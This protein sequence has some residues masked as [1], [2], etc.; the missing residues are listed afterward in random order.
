MT[1]LLEV[2]DVVK[3]FGGG[4]IRKRFMTALDGFSLTVPADRPT[5]TAIAGESGSGKTTLARLILGIIAP[6]EGQIIYRGRD[7]AAMSRRERR[8]FRREVQ[9]IFQDPYEVYNPFYKVDHVLDMVITNFGL[10]ANADEAVRLK[11]DAVEVVGLRPDDVLGKFPHELSGGQRQRVMVARAFLSRPRLIVADEPVSMV[12]A[13]L[14]ALILE[15]MLRLRDEYRISFL[16]ITHDLSTAF[17]LSDDIYVLYQ[18]AVAEMG[19]VAGPIQEPKHPYTQ[20]LVGSVPLPD[21]AVRWQG[22]V[23]LPPD[24]RMGAGAAVGCRYRNRCPHAM[25]RCAE[26]APPLYEMTPEHHAA[27]Y[28]YADRPARSLAEIAGREAVG[29]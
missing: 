5:I 1:P 29:V 6:S 18:G 24:D 20:L 8:E 9:A 26:A 16:Y 17:Q 12:D 2:R 19:A 21:P 7:L 22:R 14:R 13:S 10:A 3:R 15:V 11:R 4:L 27:C 25:A 28:L 23:E